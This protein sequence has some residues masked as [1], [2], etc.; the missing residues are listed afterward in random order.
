MVADVLYSVRVDS[1]CALIET[2]RLR[3][4]VRSIDNALRAE[5]EYDQI[6]ND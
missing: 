6:T 3:D 4:V 5:Y 2:T 1:N